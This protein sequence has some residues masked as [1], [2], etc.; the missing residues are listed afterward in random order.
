VPGVFAGR[1]DGVAPD[2]LLGRSAARSC[3]A[4]STRPLTGSGLSGT[5]TRR[6]CPGSPMAYVEAVLQPPSRAFTVYVQ[7]KEPAA[8]GTADD[9]IAS[10][11]VNSS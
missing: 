6:L 5:V 9:V 10:L 3:P 4:S 11:V 1:A 8:A 7:V 2:V